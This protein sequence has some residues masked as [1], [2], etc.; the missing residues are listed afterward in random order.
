MVDGNVVGI[1]YKL[2]LMVPHF[3]RTDALYN[4]TTSCWKKKLN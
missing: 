3:K 1:Q 2:K 4:V